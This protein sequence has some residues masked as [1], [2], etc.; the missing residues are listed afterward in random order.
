M[1]IPF[2][3][4]FMTTLHD[5]VS[6]S[7]GFLLICSSA[8]LLFAATAVPDGLKSLILLYSKLKYK[9]M[10]ATSKL[11]RDVVGKHSQL[12]LGKRI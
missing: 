3:F 4:S 7:T 2:L 10:N 1:V 6:G 11:Y 8:G 9:W 5:R 12:S